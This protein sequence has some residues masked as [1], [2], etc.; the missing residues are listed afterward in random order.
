MAMPSDEEYLRE[1]GS[2]VAEL[3]RAKGLTQKALAERA[4]LSLSYVFR[5]ERGSNM[6]METLLAVARALR[7]RVETFF[8]KQATQRAAALPAEE[9]PMEISKPRM[10]ES[11]VE[12]VSDF[13]EGLDAGE[14]RRAMRLLQA[15]FPRAK[16]PERG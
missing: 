9:E 13:V 2:R 12:R 10:R 11:A 8:S 6:S 3:R 1:I 7:V 5:L 15:A 14:R 4:R 16:T